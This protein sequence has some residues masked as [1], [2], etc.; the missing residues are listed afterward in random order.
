MES[1]S[2]NFGWI[3]IVFTAVVALGFGS[4]QLWSVNREIRADRE[5]KERDS[6]ASARHPVGEHELD[7]R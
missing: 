3:E 1:V 7:E 6:A 5:A 4:Y 2:Q